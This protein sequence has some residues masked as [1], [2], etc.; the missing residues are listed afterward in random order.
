MPVPKASVYEHDL[1]TTHENEVRLSR[2]I[3]LVQGISISKAMHQRA[4]SDLRRGVAS[5]NQRH[6]LASHVGAHSI[7]RSSP[8]LFLCTLNPNVLH[9]FGH[10]A[11]HEFLDGQIFDRA[12]YSQQLVK[13]SR[14]RDVDLS[15]LRWELTHPDSP[16][17]H[18][19]PRLNYTNG[20][21]TVQNP[22]KSPSLQGRAGLKRNP[23][24]GGSIHFLLGPTLV[25][26]MSRAP[27]DLTGGSQSA[28]MRTTLFLKRSPHGQEYQNHRVEGSPG[29][30]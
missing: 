2:Q 7:H 29:T 1:P 25:R 22:Y 27:L 16:N 5:L 8:D 13:L 15:F 20:T 26:R 18:S 4:N 11:L 24:F 19:Y 9:R 28:T 21:P 3:L 12:L 17:R 6:D 30:R 23:A 14:E 10:E